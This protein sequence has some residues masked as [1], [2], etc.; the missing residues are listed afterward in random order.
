VLVLGAAVLAATV[1][2][3]TAAVLL[4]G[5]AGHK[6]AHRPLLVVVG[7]SFAAGVGPDAR[8]E[9]WPEDLARILHYRLAVAADPGAGYVNPGNGHRGPFSRLAAGLPLS[10]LKP[11]VVVIQG[12]HDDIGR[13][14]GA[15][16]QRVEL[17]VAKLRRT[18]PGARLAILTVFTRGDTASSAAVATDR[19]LVTS[20][21]RADP[22]IVVFDPLTGHWRFPRARDHLHPTSTG[23]MWI[24][25]RLAAGLRGGVHAR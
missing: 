24:A 13:P 20:A 2:G 1:A 4:S 3:V 7:A 25:E 6:R 21:R 5:P 11:A 19:T 18:V 22:G 17:L 9:A 23:D 16:A 15:I 8:H 14:L 10:R 12:G